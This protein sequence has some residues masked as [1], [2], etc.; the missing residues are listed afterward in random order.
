MPDEKYAV[1]TRDAYAQLNVKPNS[2]AVAKNCS[3]V[4]ATP[5]VTSLSA[6]RLRLSRP[7]VDRSRVNAYGRPPMVAVPMTGPCTDVGYRIGAPLS[8]PAS[9]SM[10][11]RH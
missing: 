5:S 4:G 9:N 8:V 1:V 2:S 11:G 10:N 6:A 7:K 3:G